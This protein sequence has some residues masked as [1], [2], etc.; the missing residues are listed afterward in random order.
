MHLAYPWSRDL[1]GLAFVYRNVWLDLTWSFLLS[2]SHCRL[3]LH[4]AIEVLP[5]E[6]RLMV[7]GDNWHAEETFGAMS[8]ARRLI[9][10]VLEEKLAAGYFS[11]ADA[12]RLARRI[13]H[14]NARAFFR[15]APAIS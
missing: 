13:L 6:T 5:D 14:D 4:E 1:L 8:T 9:A 7:G 3:A 12:E 10:G 2:P 11:R 15:L